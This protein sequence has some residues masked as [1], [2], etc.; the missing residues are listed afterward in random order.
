MYFCRQGLQGLKHHA[1]LIDLYQSVANQMRMFVL[2]PTRHIGMSIPWAHLT[3]M[4]TRGMHIQ[5][6]KRT[7][8]VCA[9][10]MMVACKPTPSVVSDPYA[11]SAIE[12][13]S[14][15][16]QVSAV[17]HTGP[18]A[19][20]NS[21]SYSAELGPLDPAPIKRVQLDT[22]HKVIELSLIHISEPTRPY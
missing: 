21:L 15:P 8:I 1:S 14:P 19:A 7:L 11:A 22:T 16:A 20:G 4:D 17:R 18:Y 5:H 10:L 6:L 3:F 2:W 9:W 12:L 13:K